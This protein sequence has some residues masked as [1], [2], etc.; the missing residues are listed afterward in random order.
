MADKYDPEDGDRESLASSASSSVEPHPTDT[1]YWTETNWR[2]FC[3][4]TTMHGWYFLVDESL[5]QS[6]L[7]SHMIR[8]CWAAVIAAMTAFGFYLIAL[9]I[10][11]YRDDK[12]TTDYNLK[13]VTES[14]TYFPAITVC[15]LNLARFSAVHSVSGQPNLKDMNHPDVQTLLGFVYEGLSDSDVDQVP[16]FV[17]KVLEG[18]EFKG[19]VNPEYKISGI[20][21]WL[22]YK[23]GGDLKEA[24]NREIDHTKYLNSLYFFR[25]FASQEL[26]QSRFL[27]ASYN[28]QDMDLKDFGLLYPFFDTDAG[29]CSYIHPQVFFDPTITKNQ[30][31]E[32]LLDHNYNKVKPGIPVGKNR[33]L[34]LLFDTVWKTNDLS[35][36]SYASISSK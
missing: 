22:Y 32:N 27:R 29:F 21:T 2:N 12:T 23:N 7:L 25:L 1:D 4:S 17:S 33:G 36:S 34:Y 16:E 5:A 15:S 9:I 11:D 18:K 20:K 19:K 8:C 28:G 35:L 26:S 13:M 10:I 24:I 6:Q 31:Y 14:N 3:G 30:S